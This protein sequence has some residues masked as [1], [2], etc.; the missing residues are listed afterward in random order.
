MRKETK[1]SAMAL[2]ITLTAG[3]FAGCGEKE[4]E[5]EG[6]TSTTDIEISYWNAGL[7][8]KWLDAVIEGF[9]KKYPEYNVYYTASASDTTASFGLEDTDTVDLYMAT[10]EYQQKYMEPLNEVL[11]TT[12]EGETKSIKEKFDAAYLKMEEVDGNYYN[13]TYGGG[14]LGFVYNKKM[15]E[16][17]GITQVPRTTDEFVVACSKLYD[18][19]NV[20]L[21]HYKPVG[22]YN[23]LMEAWYAQY[24]GVDAYYDFY[25]NPS[26]E[27]MLTED[28]R[29]ETIKVME[30][31]A[32]PEFTLK[33]SN[34]TDHVSM[35]TKFLE[36]SCAMMLTGSWLSSEM[37]NS[38][39]VGNFAM[40]KTPVISS[41]TDKLTTVKSE[42]TLRDLILAIDNVT[43]GVETVDTYRSGEDY[44]V[45]GATVSAADWDY[46]K[47]A[48]NMMPDN[49]NAHSLY[50]PNYSN[51]KEGAKAFLKYFY[52]DEGYQLYQDALHLTYPMSL[53]TA[54]MDTSEW[55]EFEKNQLQ[56]RNTTEY[57][58]S[59]RIKNKHRIFIDGGT[60]AFTDYEFIRKMSSA[61]EGDR[62]S[63][64][65]VWKEMMTLVEEDYEIWEKSIK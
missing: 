5:P 3:C 16:E 1:W 11:D 58:I 38:N 41:I 64:A 30:K 17:A 51:A 61:N 44:V 36:G 59:N 24:E 21:C 7:G 9:E 22:Y 63:S 65:D 45:N 4:T 28:G 49:C 43:D 40:M 29:H 39:K 14:I 27:K 20:P 15:F 50:I 62:V 57:S 53:D 12:V 56:L 10:E 42:K 18:N 23:F 8:T 48:R 31:I 37:T 46:V 47:A 35:Q 25:A 26:K 55:N 19:G 6:G 33:G 60:S 52:S 34:S 54:E 32:T 2:A 13:L